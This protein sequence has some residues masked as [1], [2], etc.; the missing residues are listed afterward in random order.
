[1]ALGP[2]TVEFTPPQQPPVDAPIPPEEAAL[3]TLKE[4]HDR[5][6][7]RERAAACPKTWKNEKGLWRLHLLPALGSFRMSELSSVRFERFI[8]GV[9]KLDGGAFG[10]HSLFR[11]RMAYK[12][13][14]DAAEFADV[15]VQPHK[16]KELR[17]KAKGTLGA[18]AV[19]TPAEVERI[20][21]HADP[22]HAALF[23][24]LFYTGSR[25]SEAARLR[26]SAFDWTPTDL[27]PYGR[28]WIDGRKTVTSN[29]WLPVPEI[30]R[31]Q[32]LSLRP[33][34]S[35]PSMSGEFVVD[36][37]PV[38]THRGVA[39]AD[40]KKALRP[41]VK[42]AEF[43]AGR[44]IFRYLF[45]HSY[46]CWL[47]ANGVTIPNVALLMRHTSEAMLRRHCH[48]VKVADKVDI[49]S[50]LSATPPA[51]KRTSFRRIGLRTRCA[52]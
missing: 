34:P 50:L 45:R 41:A 35:P 1:M 28:I 21:K 18:Y 36:D 43:P 25:P 17:G 30:L 26:W 22:V 8:S 13:L 12:A 51:P 14:V 9:H 29:D 32:I 24:Y 48:H 3:M 31:A 42:R 46:A 49:R 27:A 7:V 6:W 38:F 15:P 11:I 2:P 47:I 40:F 19:L 10:Y 4:Y 5:V 44:R 23:L 52:G 33:T 20:C 39:F 37:K 16:Y